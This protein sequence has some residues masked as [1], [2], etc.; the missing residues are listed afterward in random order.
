[1]IVEGAIQV[2]SEILVNTATEGLQGNPQI[3]TL[4]NGGFVADFW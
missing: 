4:P 2:G 3:T 1:M